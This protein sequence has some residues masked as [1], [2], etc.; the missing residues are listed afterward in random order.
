MYLALGHYV[1]LRVVHI[2]MY[3]V[4]Y[5]CQITQRGVIL[6]YTYNVLSE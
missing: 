2:Y 4:E 6:L 3:I 1:S 5:A